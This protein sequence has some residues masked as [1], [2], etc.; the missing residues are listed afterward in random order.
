MLGGG[1]GGLKEGTVGQR[2]RAAKASSVASR[3]FHR[4]RRYNILSG[5]RHTTRKISASVTDPN[6]L[7]SSLFAF[8]LVPRRAS[9]LIR[10]SPS[11]SVNTRQ[12]HRGK[13]FFLFEAHVTLL[14]VI[15]R[16]RRGKTRL[17]SIEMCRAARCRSSA[18]RLPP[19]PSRFSML[20]P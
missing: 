20:S 5:T 2:T 13:N 19:P 8:L 11:S 6:F 1:G 17:L 7:L 4:R 3:V 15:G 10:S 16:A 18:W 9:F 12:T 14:A